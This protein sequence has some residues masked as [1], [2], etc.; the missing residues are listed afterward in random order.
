MIYQDTVQPL[1]GFQMLS[2]IGLSLAI[3]KSFYSFVKKNLLRHL[4]SLLHNETNIKRN[5]I[6]DVLSILDK[7]SELLLNIVRILYF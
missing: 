6:R 2:T 4:K 7:F 1:L 5:Q 3:G